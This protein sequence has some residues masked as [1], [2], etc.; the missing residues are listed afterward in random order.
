M[1]DTVED[2]MESS[3]PDTVQTD[4]D[5]LEELTDGTPTQEI[6]EVLLRL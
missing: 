3:P 2:L 4:L 6:Y 1:W 5:R